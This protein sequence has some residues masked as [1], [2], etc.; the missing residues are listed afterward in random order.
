MFAYHFDDSVNAVSRSA[1]FMNNSVASMAAHF[2][3]GKDSKVIDFGC[4]PGLYTTRLAKFGAQVTGIDFSKHSLD[5]AKKLAKTE[6]VDV[7]Y[8]CEDYLEVELEEKY[9][10][11]ILIMCDYCALAPQQR[12]KLLDKFHS[13]LN[14]NGKVLLDVCSLEGYKKVSTEAKYEKNMLNGF[15]SKDPYY[16]FL[17]IDKYDK[18][19]ITLDKYTI[20]KN[21]TIDR[22]Y[23][24]V[25]YYDQAALSKEF[26]QSGFKINEYYSDVAGTPWSENSDEFA[27]VAIKA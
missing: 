14:K 17:N 8:L 5:Y 16:G 21:D 22:V 25:Q 13:I 2:N 15:W 3:L 6:N 19:K 11:I 20:V 4:G 9:D 1:T 23:Y 7:K 26:A 27:V 24:W 18:E 10:L 12:K